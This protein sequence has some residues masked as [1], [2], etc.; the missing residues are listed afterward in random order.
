LD[1]DFKHAIDR[2]REGEPDK[3]SRSEAIR[4]LLGEGL[5]VQLKKRRD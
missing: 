2:W 5:Q 3:P 4:W 1:L